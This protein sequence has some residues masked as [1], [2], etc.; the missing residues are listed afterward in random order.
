MD[1]MD[2]MDRATSPDPTWRK[3]IGILDT[4]TDTAV[5]K[6]TNDLET[7]PPREMPSILDF[8]HD[9]DD[10]I[11]KIHG[12]F[13]KYYIEPTAHDVLCGLML[14]ESIITSPVVAELPEWLKGLDRFRRNFLGHLRSPV[15]EVP[16]PDFTNPTNTESA[17]PTLES[18][19]GVKRKGP[20]VASPENKRSPKP[21]TGLIPRS[22]TERD[23]C[24]E[25]D[26]NKCVLTGIKDPEVYHI[27]PFAWNKSMS[28]AK[29]AFN[30]R[31]N[32]LYLFGPEFS[33]AVKAD[34]HLKSDKTL[35]LGASDYAWNMVSLTPTA[36]DWW[37]K[38]YWGFDPVEVRPSKKT[39]KKKQWEAVLLFRWTYRHP[40]LRDEKRKGCPTLNM[41]KDEAGNSQLGEFL[42]E[43]R[44]WEKGQQA[45]NIQRPDGDDLFLH[46][47]TTGDVRSGDQVIIKFGSEV[48][49][50]RFFRLMQIQWAYIRLHAMSAAA[51]S[52]SLHDDETSSSGL[53]FGNLAYVDEQDSQERIQDWLMR[54][55]SPPPIRTS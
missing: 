5:K 38:A 32:I 51:E 47:S 43:V 34:L 21:H 13:Q 14:H 33:E 27:V 15:P 30:L 24:V 45:P 35:V 40:S 11:E 2:R 54:A 25:R 22:T 49:A 29:K 4:M 18:T 19:G 17:K 20:D 8:G 44:Q 55:T 41:E 28:N 9:L 42:E 1:R 26:G 7:P 48:D 23:K 52:V 31:H 46:N 6:L 10:R 53:V 50:Q 16:S 39:G 37:G 12:L 36:H 3:L